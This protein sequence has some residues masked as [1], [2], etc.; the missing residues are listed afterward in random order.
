LTGVEAP[1][2]SETYILEPGDQL[3]VTINGSVAY[4]YYAWI[5]YEGKLTIQIPDDFTTPKTLQIVDVV[6][7]SGM[8]M[9]AAQDTLATAFRRY[10]KEVTITLTL[11]NLRNG[12]VYVAGEVL[13]PG[14]IYAS[15]VD[16]V[17]EIITRAGGLTP[18]GSRTHIQILRGDTVAAIV[19]LEKFESY[20]D[21]SANPFVQSGDR[22]LVPPVTG[23]VTVKGAV[24]GRGDYRLRTSAL[25][26]EKE[27]IS[28]GLYELTPGERVTDLITKAGGATPW[29]DLKASYVERRNAAEG[30]SVDIPVD[31]VKVI[32]QSDSTSNIELEPSDV[33]VV[34][35]INTLVYVEG[36][37]DKP[38]SYLYTPNLKFTDYLGMAGGPNSNGDVPRAWIIRAK[39]RIEAST[40]PVIQP[41]DIVY[42]PRISLRWWQDYLTIFSAIGMPL[43][44]T[45]LSIYLA[46]K[47]K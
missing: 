2:I 23:M 18:V 5:T 17:S 34:P 15:P 4:S 28:E 19:N 41:G 27:R 37:V 38:L 29:A 26:T 25:T 36:E 1:I 35:P 14:A 39:T 20:G 32:F 33:I 3:L 30:T 21:L 12:V 42:V 43:A 11:T 16:R 31:L 13:Q 46:T 45:I 24:F 47:L 10:F 40:N 6:H 44:T 7:V 8:N 22:I 9:K